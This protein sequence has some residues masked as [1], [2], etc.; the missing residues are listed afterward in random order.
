M[1]LKKLNPAPVL[2]REEPCG[3]IYGRSRSQLN[4]RFYQNGHY[5]TDRGEYVGSDADPETF[6]SGRKRGSASRQA[7]STPSDATHLPAGD[8][9]RFSPDIELGYAI[10]QYAERHPL[11]ATAAR[12]AGE[13][14]ERALEA[15]A[16]GHVPQEASRD[17]AM[18]LAKAG[19]LAEAGAMWREL[20]NA[21]RQ[22]GALEGK[23]NRQAQSYRASRRRSDN[24]EPLRDSVKSWLKGTLVTGPTLGASAYARLLRREYKR[25]LRR[26]PGARV[27]SERNLRRIITELLPRLRKPDKS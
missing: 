26:T 4:V 23:H 17:A 21:D 22:I 11:T 8:P 5:F 14:A 25:R 15:V 24:V 3:T 10:A 18:Y 2:N 13:I 27:P 9:P 20:R 16:A 19:H 12:Y 7:R 6:S 1:E